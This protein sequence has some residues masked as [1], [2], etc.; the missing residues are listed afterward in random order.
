[1]RL[2]GALIVGMAWMVALVVAFL[3]SPGSVFWGFIA[4]TVLLVVM[5]Y[6]LRNY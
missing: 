2:I 3:L 5:R 1:M 6:A 4:G